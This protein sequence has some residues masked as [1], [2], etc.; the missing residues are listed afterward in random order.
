[1]HQSFLSALLALVPLVSATAQSSLSFEKD[2]LPVFTQYCFTCHGQSSPQ[3][4]LDLRT[5]SSTLRGSHNG[6]VIVKGAPDKSLLYQKVSSKAMPPPAFK[7]TMPDAQ[8][9]IIKRWIADGAL[10]DKPVA[11][12]KEVAEQ[13]AVFE[14][15]I[16]PLLTTRCVACHGAG[17]PM[18]GLDLRS[19]QAMLKGSAN[20]AVTV[21]GFSERSV[22]VRRV[23]SRSMPPPGSGEPLSE[24]EIQNIRKWID[25]GHFVDP[26][27]FQEPKEREFTKAEAP[28]VSEKDREFWS[29]R[30]PV[31]AP[32]PRVK[33]AKRVR[34][35]IDAFVLSKLESK[36][37]SLSPDASNR[38]LM[39]RA[40]F[41]VLGVPPSPE[42]AAAF[43]NDTKPEAYE[44]LL[45]R[46][47]ASPRYGER[48]GR[49][50]LDAAGYVDTQAKDFDAVKYDIA[51]GMWH[52][53]DYVIKATND[54]KPWNRF[55][56]EQLAGDELIDWRTAK[57]YTPEII[58]SL[59]ATGYLRNVLDITDDDITN[60]PVERYEALFKLMEKVS[61]STMGLTMACARCHTHKFDP[62][63]QRDY[64]RM[65]ALFTN[66]LNPTSWVQPKKRIQY[67]VSKAEQEE[68]EAHNKEVDRAVGVLKE[69]LAKVR[70]PYERRLLEEKLKAIPEAIRDDVRVALAAAEDKRNEVQKFLVLKFGKTLAVSDAEVTKAL[71]ETDAPSVERLE[72]QI[73][74]SN[75]YRRKLDVIQAIWDV[76]EPPSI[77]L[78]QRGSAE[79]PGPKVTP[80]FLTV[81]TAPDKLEA[82]RPPET[83]GKT[84]GL[85][86]AFSNWLGSREN[87]LTARVIVNRIWQHHFGKGIVETPDNFGKMGTPPSNQELLDWL[88]VN[89]MENGWTAKRLHKMILT[90]TVYRQSSE[91]ENQ[92]AKAADPENKLLWRMNMRRLEAEALRDSILSASGKLD[93]TMGGPPVLLQMRP[94]GLETVSPKETAS[95]QNRRSVYLLARRTYPLTMLGLFDFPIIDANCTRRVPSSTPLQALTL[96][97]DEFVVQSA[98]QLAQR[99]AKIAGDNESRV[100]KIEALYSIALLRKPTQ[101]EILACEE[102]LKKQYELFTQANVAPAEAD[103][104]AF[105][106]LSQALLSSNEFLYID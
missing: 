84:S 79:S 52:Y 72:S 58:E 71:N 73:R 39:R 69:Q 35:P 36:G 23:A 54:D 80:G 98:E 92:A 83:Q 86:L 77:R 103:R 16:L 27:E 78:L 15:E 1:M 41:D 104:R 34:T 28:D 65:L 22:L 17:K 81:A 85:R 56:T 38:T 42:E 96:M 63:P 62:I 14:K 20:G 11:V 7:Q 12:S 37:L 49:H 93:L 66:A 26:A 53:R 68:I 48:W 31:A 74:T 88:A 46:L 9:E 61:S 10:S 75:G 21:E 94:D 91:Q 2:V 59:T 87:P 82:T 18:G 51:E 6:P 30:K 105:D 45:D 70:G 47:L 40:Y 102:H 57:K 97:N 25:K 29:F 99:A 90:S 3:L 5:I 44:R 32:V 64:Y 19:L 33:A 76:G 60:L 95:N 106:T 13:R 8:A 43:L 101:A 100:K 24:V 50:W 55:L 67:T 89:F 4:G